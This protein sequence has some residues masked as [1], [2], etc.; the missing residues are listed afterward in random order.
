MKNWIIVAILI[1][2]AAA[3]FYYFGVYQPAEPKELTAVEAPF[4]EPAKEPEQLP[5]TPEPGPASEPVIE[6]VTPPEAE[7]APLPMLEESDPVVLESL[8]GLLG[9]PAV[10]GFIVTDNI[11][12]RVVATI[13]MLGGRQVSSVVQAVQGPAGAFEVTVNDAPESEITNEAGDPIPQFII[14]PSNY[15]RYT[16]YVEALEA[17]DT[18]ELIA[19]Y[20]GLYPLFQEAYRQMGYADGD[21]DARLAVIIDELLATPDVAGPVYLTKPEAVFL[22]ADP[23]LEALSAGQK[24]LVRMGTENASRVKSKLAEIRAEL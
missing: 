14:D 19:N 16:P 8:G 15:A 1:V 12:S 21:F 9:E 13:D 11:V 23:G 17:V 18:A 6:P 2:V 10:A 7:E 3:A 20:R 5:E 4:V 22:F 24:I